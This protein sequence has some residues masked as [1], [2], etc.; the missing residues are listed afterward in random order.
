MRINRSLIGRVITVAGVASVA[1]L[2]AVT[3]VAYGITY[4]EVSA[5]RLARMI[6]RTNERATEQMGDFE[7]FGA[8]LQQS[9]AAFQR[10]RAIDGHRRA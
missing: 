3:V 1:I 10:T 6:D 8:A 9:V 2:V 7:D 5:Y 4:K